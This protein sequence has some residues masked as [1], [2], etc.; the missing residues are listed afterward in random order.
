MQ[1][2]QLPNLDSI[3]SVPSGEYN[4]P[5]VDLSQ[6][7]YSSS[8]NETKAMPHPAALILSTPKLVWQTARSVG[9]AAPALSFSEAGAV[10]QLGS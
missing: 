9:T 6:E 4:P 10:S 2:R 8:Q 1:G 3:G 7:T 5:V